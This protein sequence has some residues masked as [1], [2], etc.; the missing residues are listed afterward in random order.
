[1]NITNDWRLCNFMPYP[2]LCDK[3]IANYSDI[4]FVIGI[5]LKKNSDLL[6][7]KNNIIN[8]IDKDAELLSDVIKNLNLNFVFCV[9]DRNNSS[10]INFIYFWKNEFIY[11][12]FKNSYTKKINI[13]DLSEDMELNIHKIYQ[14][15]NDLTLK[16]FYNLENNIEVIPNNLI[17]ISPISRNYYITNNTNLLELQNNFLEYNNA[18]LNLTFDKKNFTN[19]MN[20]FRKCILNGYFYK[21]SNIKIPPTIKI[22]IMYKN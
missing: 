10:I 2:V 8:I 11:K 18:N 4:N 12:K 21:N 1:M 14:Y 15:K 16:L 13:I 17:K 22:K 19:K 3:I 9:Y 6:E 7:I 5:I 20:S